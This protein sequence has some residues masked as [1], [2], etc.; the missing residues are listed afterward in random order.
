MELLSYEVPSY[1][2]QKFWKE[3][4]SDLTSVQVDLV[5]DTL[6]E[7][8]ML[9]SKEKEGLYLSSFILDEA[10]HTFILFTKDYATFCNDYVGKFIHH[11]PSVGEGGY[12]NDLSLIE[13][14]Y[15]SIMKSSPKSLIYSID[16]LL[17]EEGT[18]IKGIITISSEVNKRSIKL[19]GHII[20]E[21]HV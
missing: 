13:N 4:R 16:T 18:S 21:F 15:K 8:L 12:L 20:G 10:W 5:F 19:N 17:K 3:K 2:K 9:A 11:M 1:I 7:Y 6:L 14:S